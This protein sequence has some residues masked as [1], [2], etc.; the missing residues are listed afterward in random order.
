M[1][2]NLWG[3]KLSTMA[4]SSSCEIQFL[5]WEQLSR[6]MQERLFNTFC[7]LFFFQFRIK[8]NYNRSLFW[9]SETFKKDVSA[10][11]C[12]IVIHDGVE[13]RLWCR[14]RSPDRPFGTVA[15]GGGTSFSARLFKMP[16]WADYV[17]YMCPYI[18]LCGTNGLTSSLINPLRTRAHSPVISKAANALAFHKQEMAIGS[19]LQL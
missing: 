5:V 1:C 16:V 9:W 4:F 8:C 11:F 2:S 19:W 12:C 13:R 18:S 3:F 14:S 6:I 7:G 15:R 17:I 10:T